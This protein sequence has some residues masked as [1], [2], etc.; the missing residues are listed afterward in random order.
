VQNYDIKVQIDVEKCRS[1]I[2]IFQKSFPAVADNAIGEVAIWMS[3]EV[4]RRI[5]EQRYRHK[6]LSQPYLEYK[7]RVGLDTRILIATGAYVNSISARKRRFQGELCWTVGV[8]ETIH[9]GTK[10]TYSALGRIHEFGCR[11][12]NIPARPHWRPVWAIAVK[13]KFPEVLRR[14]LK[15]YMRGLRNPSNRNQKP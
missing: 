7:K 13:S 14:V 1:F 6:P 8:P 12:V 4:K 2:N 3:H 10:L 5:R 15:N 9:P 11:K